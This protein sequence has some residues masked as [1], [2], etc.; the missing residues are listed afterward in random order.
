MSLAN[1]Y[2][3]IKMLHKEHLLV[4]LDHQLLTSWSYDQKILRRF[5]VGTN[6]QKLKKYKISY[7][8][9]D[10]VTIIEKYDCPDNQYHRYFYLEAI[11]TILNKIKM[12]G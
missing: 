6:W 3:I 11:K 1:R 7:I 9:I 4:F 5:H 2:K 12:V 8:V 10:N